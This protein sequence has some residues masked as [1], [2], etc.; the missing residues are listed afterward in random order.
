M[1][2]MSR[3]TSLIRPVASSCPVAR[4]KR[5]LN[6][7]FRRSRSWV[8]NSS[9]VLA[10][11]SAILVM[12]LRL[13]RAEARHD[14]GPDRQLGGAE[15]QRLA[16]RLGRDAVDLEHHAARLDADHP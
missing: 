7:S 4:W 5:R 3:R 8:A 12:L 15:R 14:L 11:I 6:C 13:R 16:R 2:A 1:R 10:R 9:G